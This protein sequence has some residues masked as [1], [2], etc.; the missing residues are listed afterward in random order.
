MITDQIRNIYHSEVGIRLR[1]SVGFRPVTFFQPPHTKFG[2]SSCVSDLFPWRK[3]D[4]WH[5]YFH[6]MNLQSFM[7]PSEAE[8]TSVKLIIFNHEG[9]TVHQEDIHLSTFEIKKIDISSLAKTDS[10]GCFAVFHEF[11]PRNKG[12]CL[13]ERSY[14]SFTKGKNK[15]S[16]SLASFCHGNC[17]SVIYNSKKSRIESVR[18]KTR[19]RYTYQP[20]TSFRDC[21]SFDLIYSNP[22]LTPLTIEIENL[23]LDKSHKTQYVLPP[24]GTQLVE[25]RENIP[26]SVKATTNLSIFRPLITKH[27]KNGFDIFHG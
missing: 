25:Y 3:S 8:N 7:F 13:S 10:F 24:L 17:Y 11:N 19:K 9:T 18:R 6:L 23:Y 1:N 14:V 5:T 16:N 15:S 27:Y 22:L 20:Q 21:M 12:T 4:Y 2:T 26:I